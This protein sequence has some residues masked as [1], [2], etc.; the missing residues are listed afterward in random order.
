MLSAG[1]SLHLQ[2]GNVCGRGREAA[3]ARCGYKILGGD[4][5]T[6]CGRSSP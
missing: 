1:T 4:R 3:E 6:V 5:I 2:F